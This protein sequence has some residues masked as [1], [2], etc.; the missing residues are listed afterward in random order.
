M[1]SEG[2]RR[3]VGRKEER[4]QKRGQKEGIRKGEGTERKAGGR[5]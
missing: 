5:L 3:K 2:R 1:K 4:R